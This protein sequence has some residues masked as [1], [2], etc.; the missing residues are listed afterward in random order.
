MYNKIKALLALANDAGATEAEAHLALEKAHELMV[1][2][3]VEMHEEQA[4]VGSTSFEGETWNQPWERSCWHAVA[5]LFFCEYYFVSHGTNA[6][7]YVLV[8]RQ[9]NRLTA[10]ALCRYVV[11]TGKSLALQYAQ[12]RE[13]SSVS[14]SNAYKRGFAG[15]IHENATTILQKSKTPTPDGGDVS[16]AMVVID[17]TEAENKTITAELALFKKKRRATMRNKPENF[18]AM[19]NGRVGGLNTSLNKQIG[20]KTWT[21]A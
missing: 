17:Q 5:P 2:Y 19:A 12:S 11:A 6:A 14:L 8:G 20:D 1:K 16:T 21:R 3:N 18:T 9:S 4:D 13:G 15:G 10:E 7:T